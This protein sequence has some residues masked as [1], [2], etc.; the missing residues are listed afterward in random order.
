MNIE[1]DRTSRQ[2]NA[3]RLAHTLRLQDQAWALFSNRPMSTGDLALA[4]GCTLPLAG[5]LVRGLRKQER[6][7]VSAAPTFG[8]GAVYAHLVQRMG[9][10][11]TTVHLIGGDSCD[12]PRRQVHRKI[13]QQCDLHRALFGGI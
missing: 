6:L 7:G 2:T 11:P 5:R 4:M 1:I 10:L 12:T 9:M 3:Q 8:K 13:P